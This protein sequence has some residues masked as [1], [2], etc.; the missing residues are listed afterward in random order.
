LP[1]I[2]TAQLGIAGTLAYI[3]FGMLFLLLLLCY[4]ETGSRLP[5][6]AA[7][8]LVLMLAIT[9]WGLVQAQ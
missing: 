8:M 1:A 2:I 9:M 4:A 3:A 5:A 6:P 7:L